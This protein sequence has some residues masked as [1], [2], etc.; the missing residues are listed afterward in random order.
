MTM[1]MKRR[2]KFCWKKK[3]ERVKVG[4]KEKETRGD[5]KEIYR[6][7]EEDG[8]WRKKGPEKKKRQEAG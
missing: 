1:M 7:E 2:E 5:G 3:S 6:K 8:G 4:K